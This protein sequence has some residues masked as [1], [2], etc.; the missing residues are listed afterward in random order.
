MDQIL[1][2]REFDATAL[3]SVRLKLAA[4][5]LTRGPLISKV[6]EFLSGRLTAQEEAMLAEL[7]SSHQRLLQTA[8]THTSKWTL[9]AIATSWTQYRTETRELMRQWQ[10][11][12]EREQRFVYPL[13]QRC[14]RAA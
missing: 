7:R 11:K 13:V 10:T 4:I 5:R 1:A 6:A 2:K 9:D 12:V 8:T 14:A 3:T